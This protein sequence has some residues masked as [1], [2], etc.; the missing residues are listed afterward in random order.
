[1]SAIKFPITTND[2]YTQPPTRIVIHAARRDAPAAPGPYHSGAAPPFALCADDV[3]P[4]AGWASRARGGAGD[5]TVCLQYSFGT[6]SGKTAGDPS[7]CQQLHVKPAAMK[8]LRLRYTHPARAFF[9]RKLRCPLDADVAA[10]VARVQPRAPGAIYLEFLAAAC[11]ATQ[12]KLDAERKYRAF[13]ETSGAAPAAAGV[14]A[15]TVP[16]CR[17]FAA[18]GRC[19]AGAGCALLHAKIGDASTKDRLVIAT[20]ER[21]MQLAPSGAAAAAA[22]AAV[23]AAS[24]G[25]PFS[26][27]AMAAPIGAP[28]SHPPPAYS[29]APSAAP[30]GGALR[31]VDANVPASVKKGPDGSA[32]SAPDV[33]A[34]SFTVTAGW[35][36]A[37]AEPGVRAT[38][39]Q[40]SA[41]MW[42][43]LP[44]VAACIA[45]APL[46]PAKLA[47]LPVPLSAAEAAELRVLLLNFRAAF[48]T[49]ATIT[50]NAGLVA[51]EP[52]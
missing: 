21:S 31:V 28:I 19:A 1:M 35:S 11:E 41:P 40:L 6:C 15:S 4:S 16:L 24:A 29:A 8:A 42:R 36:V 50:D 52:R 44:P 26:R 38:P 13:L 14:E 7:S 48:P 47:A 51:G 12:G 25:P 34:A 45:G 10:A 46:R 23:A 39:G 17:A 22:V 2:V 9:L 43:A 49:A 33:A 5:L 37:A 20:I 27:D 3:D 18:G 32:K 30:R